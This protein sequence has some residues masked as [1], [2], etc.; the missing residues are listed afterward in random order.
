LWLDDEKAFARE[1]SSEVQF[2]PFAIAQ[3]RYALLAGL[4]DSLLTYS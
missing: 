1:P 2:A 3:R 4:F